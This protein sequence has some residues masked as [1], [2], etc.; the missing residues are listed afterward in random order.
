MQVRLAY[1]LETHQQIAFSVVGHFFC[2][3]GQILDMCTDS[4][5]DVE[6]NLVHLAYICLSGSLTLKLVYSFDGIFGHSIL[7]ILIC[8]KLS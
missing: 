5:S 4:I 3:E 1:Y 2:G 7:R 6:S 8:A